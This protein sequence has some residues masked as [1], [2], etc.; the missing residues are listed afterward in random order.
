[1][2]INQ[3]F[4]QKIVKNC[5]VKIIKKCINHKT[6]YTPGRGWYFISIL[7]TFCQY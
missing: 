6:L 4:P 2:N 3:I 7:V 5:N 1:M